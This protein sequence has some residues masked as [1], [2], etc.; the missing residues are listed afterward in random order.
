MWDLLL[1]PIYLIIL[2]TI[3]KRQRDKRYPHGHPLRRYYLPGLYVKFGGAIF[4]ACIYEFY[5]GTGGDT[6]NF[7]YHS[8]IINSSFTDSIGIWLKLMLRTPVEAAPE[9]YPYASQLFWYESVSEYT[10]S[11]IAAIFGLLCGNTYLPIA[12][13]F[14]YFSYTGIWAM[15]RT[16]VNLYP[17]MV[18]HLAYAFL[19]IPSTFVWGSAVFKDTLCMFGLGWMTYTVFRLFVNKDF[20]LRNILILGLSFYLIALIKLYILLA[21]IP[22]LSL[23]LLMTYSKNIKAVGLRWMVNIV[24]VGITIGGFLYFSQKFAVEMNEYSLENLAKTA[25]VT[26]AWTNYAAGE[27]GSTYNI[28]TIDGSIGSTISLF[29]KGVVV[30]LFRPFPWEARKVIVALSALEALV[31]LF[32]T[33]KIFLWK[34]GR[35][36]KHVAK[37]PNIL[38]FLIFA[39][40]FAFAVGVSSG[41]FGALSR[42][43][44]PCL[45][46]YAAALAILYNKQQ[47]AKEKS[48]QVVARKFQP[49]I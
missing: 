9:I 28:G 43:K 25:E 32:L 7:F 30:T 39:L 33:I 29:P 19:F 47:S 41:N 14:A 36:F 21:F 23:W 20:S 48:R 11:V 40:I 6:S 42:Y 3:A 1:T 22:A 46:F 44:I 26:R 34:R 8:K 12:L 38:F 45:P 35:A 16:F 27:E 37:D 10:V 5:Y 31:F 17:K 24:F 4:I 15:Y 49:A 18:T 13:F 2:V